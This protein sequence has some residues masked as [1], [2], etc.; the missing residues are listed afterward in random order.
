MSESLSASRIAFL[1]SCLVASRHAES[2]TSPL[3]IPDH[4]TLSPNW[5]LGYG[6]SPS[7]TLT[8]GTST[9]FASAPPFSSTPHLLHADGKCTAALAINGPF[10]RFFFHDP[11]NETGY[12][13]SIFSV[14]TTSGE[15]RSFRGPWS[16]RASA[17]SPLFPSSPLL[18]EC[19]LNCCNALTLR[20]ILHRMS[21]MDRTVPANLTGP[22]LF[23]SSKPCS[24]SNPAGRWAL[25]AHSSL[26]SP[27]EFEH[28]I[29][30]IIILPDNSGFWMKGDTEAH[31]HT[32]T[33]AR[34]S[35]ICILDPS[36]RYPLHIPAPSPRP[37]DALIPGRVAAIQSSTCMPAPIGC[38]GPATTFRDTISRAEYAISG[39]CQSCQDSIFKDP[40]EVEG[41]PLPTSN[42][43]DDEV[44][45]YS[46]CTEPDDEFN[47]DTLDDDEDLDDSEAD[48]DDEDD[49][50]RVLDE[51]LTSDDDNPDDDEDWSEAEYESGST[52]IDMGSEIE[53]KDTSVRPDPFEPL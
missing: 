46:L 40:K 10:A 6:N 27:T 52:P 39:L 53:S 28:Y 31:G 42:T 34:G 18:C 24:L 35:Q 47:D 50:D 19:S 4:L 17:I 11:S 25:L 37:V 29:T 44:K 20:S 45:Q 51:P 30:P 7:L 21:F 36:T 26:Y 22:G 23:G 41:S 49:I 3:T 15:T 8:E 9:S 16:S 2:L 12:G 14:F 43:A 5:C 33:L 1:Q 48:E 32:S 38:G 13:G